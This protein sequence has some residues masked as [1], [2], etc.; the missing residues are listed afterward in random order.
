MVRFEQIWRKL[1]QSFELNSV[2]ERGRSVTIQTILLLKGNIKERFDGLTVKVHDPNT[3]RLVKQTVY[4]TNKL[5]AASHLVQFVEGTN[6]E[7]DG[8]KFPFLQRCNG[9]TDPVTGVVTCCPGHHVFD[10]RH[11]H[12]N[13][14]IYEHTVPV[15]ALKIRAAKF[16][17]KCFDANPGQ[18]SDDLAKTILQSQT[19]MY[20]CDRLL[21]PPWLAFRC[22]QCDHAMVEIRGCA[23]SSAAD[24]R[25][26]LD[27]VEPEL[28]S[29]P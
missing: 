11:M 3:N 6:I 5:R 22:K 24:I 15:C 27:L 12:L 7:I 26:V 1:T 13:I 25:S 18:S 28:P 2:G 9:T 4:H 17:R 10:N 29:A 23:N 8:V 19:W 20:I 21:E 16:I 14:M